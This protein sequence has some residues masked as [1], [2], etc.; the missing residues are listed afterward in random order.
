MK[1]LKHDIFPDAIL[2]LLEITNLYFG[3]S[4]FSKREKNLNK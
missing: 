4:H 2:H 1:Y 3:H